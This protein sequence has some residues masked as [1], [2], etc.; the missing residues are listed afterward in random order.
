[1]R[2]RSS[3]GKNSAGSLVRTLD[4]FWRRL[5][6]DAF[7]Y[8]SAVFDIF[9]KKDGTPQ[10]PNPTNSAASIPVNFSVRIRMQTP[11]HPLIFISTSA[12]FFSPSR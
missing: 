11:Q 7:A 8:L 2:G 10:H 5:K 9:V 12:E 4:F 3:G 1:M 6:T